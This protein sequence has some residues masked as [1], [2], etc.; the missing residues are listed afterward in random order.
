MKKY[1]NCNQIIADIDRAHAK[2]AKA[3][4]VAQE[5]IDAESFL[6]G[7]TDLSGLSL[8]REAADKQFR[9]IERL[10]NV[11][12]KKLGEKLAEM[13]TMSLENV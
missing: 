8:H 7:T 5:H 11:R 3:K 6:T 9:K 10:Q 4:L 13:N 1:T 2:I 12:L